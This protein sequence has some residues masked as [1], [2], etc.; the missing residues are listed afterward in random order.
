MK[1]KIA[2]EIPE[3][4]LKYTGRKT[5]TIVFLALLTC[6]LV[7]LAINAGSA[8]LNPIQIIMTL[9]GKGDENS[10][11]VI[12]NIHSLGS[13]QRLSPEQVYPWPVVSCKTS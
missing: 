10:R 8:E 3:G 2:Q 12:W 6:V 9:L 4:Y 1:T 7:V 5:A 11:V 13:W